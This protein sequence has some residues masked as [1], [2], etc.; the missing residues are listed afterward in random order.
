MPINNENQ[1]CAQKIDRKLFVRPPKEANQEGVL[2]QLLQG[3]YGILDGGRLFY[4]KLAKTLMDLGM[5]QIHSDGA[6]FTYVKEEKF[7]GLVVTNTDDLI[8]AGDAQFEE[9]IV[10]KLKEIFKFSKIEEK[11]FNYCGCNIENNKDGSISLNQNDYVEN[12]KEITE[13]DSTEERKL[14]EKEKTIVKSKIGELLWLSLLT[15]PD[16][17]FEVNSISS[18]VT[19]GSTNLVN[20]INLIIK[21]AKKVKYELKFVRLGELSDL[22]V[23]VFADA[24]FCNQ[25]EKTRSTEGRVVM[26]AN[27]NNKAVNIVSWKTK[28]IP[29]VCRSVKA[30]ETRALEEAIDD[31]VNLA[32]IIHEIYKGQVDLKHPDQ[33]PVKA[34]SDSKSLWE[35]LHNSR[36][37]EEKMLRCSI[38]GMKELLDLGIV[39]DV[40]WVPTNSQLADCLTK[41]GKN[42]H[43]LIKVASQNTLEFDS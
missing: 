4:L 42:A 22:V 19:D 9:D 21:K 6:L 37:C 16:L 32:R 1:I 40:S 28:K 36:Q 11:N 27:R 30:A 34:Y 2:W 12:L 25:D 39:Q 15:R 33:V 35:S 17:S 3:A 29:R 5:H 26:L 13:I 18:L 8:L 31:A 38:A 20:A 7:H 43:W 14:D 24:S 23:K 41:R 10:F